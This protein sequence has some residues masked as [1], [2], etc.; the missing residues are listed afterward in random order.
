M[1]AVATGTS[2]HPLGAAS[3][4]IAALGLLLSVALWWVYFDRDDSAAVRALEQ[5][6]A[7]ERPLKVKVAYGYWHYALLLGIIATAAGMKDAV[8]GA[9]AQRDS[10]ARVIDVT[11]VNASAGFTGPAKLAAQRHPPACG[12]RSSGGRGRPGSPR[13]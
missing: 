4:G 10:A 9:R 11:R 2:A 3:L 1:I 12:G 8:S 7:A 13:T 5:A 6:P